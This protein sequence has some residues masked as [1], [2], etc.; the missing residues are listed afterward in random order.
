MEHKSEGQPWPWIWGD[1]V[2]KI[3]MYMCSEHPLVVLFPVLQVRENDSQN[4]VAKCSILSVPGWKHNMKLFQRCMTQHTMTSQ[5]PQTL[6]DVSRLRRLQLNE[7]YLSNNAIIMLANNQRY[8][9]STLSPLHGCYPEP[10]CIAATWI[11]RAG[12]FMGELFPLKHVQ[13]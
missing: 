1:F 11:S 13:P 10:M 12:P 9:M 2:T 5:R 3:F 7:G 8:P 6:R 4:I